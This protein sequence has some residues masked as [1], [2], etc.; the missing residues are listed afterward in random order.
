M[1]LGK[2]N[3]SKILTLIL[4]F[5]TSLALIGIANTK[6]NNIGLA[7]AW[8][9]IIGVLGMIFITVFRKITGR[10]SEEVEF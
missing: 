9:V 8:G 4:G 7:S 10:F 1:T 2:A 3:K 5:I 6:S